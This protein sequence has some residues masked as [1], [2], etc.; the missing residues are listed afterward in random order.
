MIKNGKLCPSYHLSKGA[1]LIGI[2]NEEGKYDILPEPI[3][4]DDE[5]LEEFQS[6]NTKAEKVLR[7]TNK[8]LESGC[9]QWTGSQCSVIETAIKNVEQQYIEDHLPVC[10]I[11]SDCRWYDQRGS[12]AC[13]VCPLVTNY[14]EDLSKDEFFNHPKTTD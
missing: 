4:I 3:K 13:K 9:K 7:F 8:C 11:R 14:V 2:K 1:S 12:E 5:L 10:A 6:H